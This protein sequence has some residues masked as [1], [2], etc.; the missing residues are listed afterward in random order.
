MMRSVAQIGWISV[1]LLISTGCGYT[2]T[3]PFPT[4]IQRVHVEM[5]HS[6]EFRRELE[7]RLTEAIN[8]RIEMDTPYRIVS[9][10][11]AESARYLT[12]SR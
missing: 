3:R 2:T 5:F 12:N 1:I 8:K 9:R 6:R 11:D 10:A 7:F 4:D